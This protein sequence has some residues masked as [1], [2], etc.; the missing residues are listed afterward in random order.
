MMTPSSVLFFNVSIDFSI[1][2]AIDGVDSIVSLAAVAIDLAPPEEL[3]GVGILSSPAPPRPNP[4]STPLSGGNDANELN[5]FRSYT[6]KT[7]RST[8]PDAALSNA[9]VA[10]HAAN[11]VTTLQRCALS[12]PNQLDALDA[13]DELELVA[14]PD[15]PLVVVVVV[16]SSTSPR[17][18]PI[19]IDRSIDRTTRPRC[20]TSRARGVMSRERR[21]TVGRVRTQCPVL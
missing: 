15:D 2:K 12:I 1:V 5:A 21:P 11:A 7:P 4:P 17:E 9:N 18:P 14:R 19:A 3:V 6:G 10:P 13:L 20:V 8:V 16:A